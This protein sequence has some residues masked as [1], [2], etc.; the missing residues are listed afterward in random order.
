M[1]EVAAYE[2]R[3]KSCFSYLSDAGILG[4]SFNFINSIIGSGVIGMAYAISLSGIGM[5]FI[6]LPLVAIL[7]GL[8]WCLIHLNFYVFY[9]IF[10]D[11][12]ILIL[13][14][15]GEKAGVKTYQDLVNVTI[16]RYGTYFLILAQFLYPFIG[17]I[18]YNII[19]GDTITKVA[20]RLF[21]GKNILSL[22]V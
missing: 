1:I 19:I 4:T 15:T 18:S 14:N 9:I 7:T 6:L 13:I 10:L 12:S 17:L 8:F 2:S 20:M 3:N 21:K 22:L 16:G 11:Y 5:A